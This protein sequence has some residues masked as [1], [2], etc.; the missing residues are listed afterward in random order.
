MYR[1]V[2]AVEPILCILFF[3]SSTVLGIF[4]GSSLFFKKRLL[5]RSFVVLSTLPLF[6]LASSLRLFSNIRLNLVVSSNRV[7]KHCNVREG[8]A[9]VNV[10]NRPPRPVR[11]L[12]LRIVEL[13]EFVLGEH[14]VVAELYRKEFFRRK[15]LCCL[16]RGFG[17]HVANAVDDFARAKDTTLAGVAP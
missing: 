11:V 3:S 16:Q 6:S 12:D 4:G 5:S 8:P 10:R 1:T 7:E 13:P 15:Q 17:P 14:Q 9:T 2:L